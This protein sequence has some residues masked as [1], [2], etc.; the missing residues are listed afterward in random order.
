MSLTKTWYTIEEATSKYGISAQQLGRWLELGTV[1]SEKNDGLTLVN[2]NDIEQEL[3][4]VP[5]I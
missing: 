4:L 2:C 1:R 3:G 5:S